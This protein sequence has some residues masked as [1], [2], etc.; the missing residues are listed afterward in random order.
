MSAS[1]PKRS[2]SGCFS[3][4]LAVVLLAAVGGLGTAIY[5]ALQVQ[6][7]SD[8]SDPTP[9]LAAAPN[10]DV[11]AVLENAIERGFKVSLSEAEINRWLGQTLATHQGGLLAGKVSLDRVWV[12]LE[13]GHAEVVMARSFLGKPFTVSMFLQAERL[14]G[15]QGTATEIR[16]HGGPYHPDFPNPPRGG[17]FGKLVVPQGFLILVMPAYK[18]LASLFPDEIRLAF[19]EM[20][21]INLEKGRIVLDPR[22]PLGDQGMRE[23]F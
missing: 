16:L 21:R 13:E 3:K 7:L 11:K 5:Y 17:R 23:T 14:E 9:A 22:S 2:G 6:N 19:Q 12:R 15:M 10:R 4:L 20:E 1:T 18:K 8:L